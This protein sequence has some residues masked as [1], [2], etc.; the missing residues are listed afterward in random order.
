MSGKTTTMVVSDDRVYSVSAS[1]TGELAIGSTKSGKVIG[2]AH[3]GDRH[4]HVRFAWFAAP[5]RLAVQTAR[6]GIFEF[7]ID[8]QK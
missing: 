6:G 2:R 5:R 7:E 3:F 8:G 1:D 4:D